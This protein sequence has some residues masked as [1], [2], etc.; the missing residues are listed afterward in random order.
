MG[1][2]AAVAAVTDSNPYGELLLLSGSGNPELSERIARE[3]VSSS[4]VPR[5]RRSPRALWSLSERV[6]NIG[7]SIVDAA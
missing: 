7:A 5:P 6:S 1:G 4:R 2:P 3:I